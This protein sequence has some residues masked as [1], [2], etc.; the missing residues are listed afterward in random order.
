MSNKVFSVS[1]RDVAF[2]I[3]RSFDELV[4]LRK[5][6][7]GEFQFESGVVVEEPIGCDFKNEYRPVLRFNRLSPEIFKKLDLAPDSLNVIVTVADTALHLRK[8]VTKFCA[9]E[10]IES[11]TARDVR[12][13]LKEQANMG[14]FG[15]LEIG[16]YLKPKHSDFESTDKMI[17][18]SS[19]VLCAARFEFKVATE[20][21]V[22]RLHFVPFGDE[23]KNVVYCVKWISDDVI[24]GVASDSFEVHIN[25]ELKNEFKLLESNKTFG[26][27]GTRFLFAGILR[28]IIEGTLKRIGDVGDTEIE[29]AGDSAYGFVKNMFKAAGF[30]DDWS[31][32]IQM[33]NE[34][35]ITDQSEVSEMALKVAQIIAESGSALSNQYY[36]QS[37][38]SS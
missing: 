19:Q 37:L 15:G 28:E 33:A 22:F 10:L 14:F 23:L 36:P 2:N 4:R 30:V 34:T 32:Y 6:E 25:D 11:S 8:I 27:L 13:P 5:N 1:R 24:S 31:M 16:V 38:G 18:H 26:P 7:T 17:W 21:A 9:S 12:V 29:A 35:N 3:G 20:D